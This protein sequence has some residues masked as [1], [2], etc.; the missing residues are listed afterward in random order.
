MPR[1]VLRYLR[2]EGGGHLVRVDDGGGGVGHAR[3][4]LHTIRRVRDRRRP[5][6]EASLAEAG[7]LRLGRQRQLLVPR[8]D[9]AAVG[10]ALHRDRQATD[11]VRKGVRPLS[12]AVCVRACRPMREQ[13]GGVRCGST[14]G[15]RRAARARRGSLRGCEPLSMVSARRI[16]PAQMPHAG[17]PDATKA[18]TGSS[19]AESMRPT[20]IEVDS[21]PGRMRASTE[22]RCAGV[23]TGTPTTPELANRLTAARC[24]ANEPWSARTPTRIV[25]GR[26]ASVRAFDELGDEMRRS[27]P[28]ETKLIVTETLLE[29]SDHVGVAE[30]NDR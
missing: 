27:T 30:G 20:P 14:G 18:F 3:E 7:L 28:P 8:V 4:H 10:V 9:L 21:P 13:E 29:R 25:S 5:D 15:A 12:S 26:S 1:V 6:E 23:V 2:V 11:C 19:R 24:S 16:I 17:F 22:A